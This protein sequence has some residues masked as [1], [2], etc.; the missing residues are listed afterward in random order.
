M[1]SSPV[2]EL[3]DDDDNL[4][5]PEYHKCIVDMESPLDETIELNKNV[6]SIPPPP[7]SPMVTAWG[8]TDDVVESGLFFRKR[9]VVSIDHSLL[10]GKTT[11]DP[12]D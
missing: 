9:Q 11:R 6:G 8:R 10:N 3:V 1:K 12:Q 2:R 4:N 7:E 5:Y